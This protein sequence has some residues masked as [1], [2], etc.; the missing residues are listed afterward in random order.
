MLAVQRAMPFAG[1]AGANCYIFTQ[2][3]IFIKK[4]MLIYDVVVQQNIF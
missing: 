3:L 1:E 4:N 2:D